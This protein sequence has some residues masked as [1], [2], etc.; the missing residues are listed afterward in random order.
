MHNFHCSSYV[1]FVAGFVDA[2]AYWRHWYDSET[3]REECEEVLEQ[4]RPLY[5]HLHAYVR[6]KLKERYSTHS[7]PSEGHIPAHLLGRFQSEPLS[8]FLSLTLSLFLSLSLSLS[9]SL[10]FSLSLFLSLSISRSLFLFV[11]FSPS[12][13]PFSLSK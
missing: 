2:G 11:C 7:F 1:F 4:L 13:L 6:N 8:L 9:D 3:F 12:L 10:S 5:Q